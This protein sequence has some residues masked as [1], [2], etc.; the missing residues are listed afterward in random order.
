MTEQLIYLV[1]QPGSGKSTLMVKLTAQFDRHS[2]A[3]AEHYPV[4][5]DV[6]TDKKTGAVVAAEI[7]KQREL[8]SGT[9]AL[10]SSVI[11]KAAPWVASQPYPL[12][13]AE[14]ARLANKRFLEAAM[15]GGYHVTLVLLDHPDAE[16][17]RA[18]RSKEIGKVQN[19][20]WVKGRLS[21]S[22]NLATW[23][24]NS[25]L[26]GKDIEVV[27]G[28]PDAVVPLLQPILDAR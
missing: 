16:K 15:A 12:V 14:G 6:L 2:I 26:A 1:G 28:H 7:G 24:V 10:A 3:P 8:F 25:K 5:H 22:R 13:L 23:A 11:D 9:D 17:W 21:A 18:K 27:V 19:E 4:A 20:G